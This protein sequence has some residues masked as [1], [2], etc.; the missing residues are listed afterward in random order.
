MQ[1][2]A[3]HRA[4]RILRPRVNNHKDRPGIMYQHARSRVHDPGY[5][6]D[7]G[8]HRAVG[9]YDDIPDRAALLGFGRL[10]DKL[11]NLRQLLIPSSQRIFKVPYD[12]VITQTNLLLSGIVKRICQGDFLVFFEKMLSSQLFCVKMYSRI[13]SKVLL[14]KNRKGDPYARQRCFPKRSRPVPWV[15][16]SK[17][18][19]LS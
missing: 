13:Y 9:I 8:M 7:D 5:G 17:L 16:R 6:K 2:I 12:P 4:S 1:Y 10:R 14:V 11:P 18:I 15:R 19:T 3:Y